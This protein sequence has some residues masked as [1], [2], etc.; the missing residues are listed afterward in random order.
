[1]SKQLL[2]AALDNV[3]EMTKVLEQAKDRDAAYPHI[4]RLNIIHAALLEAKKVL[5]DNEIL[6]ARIAASGHIANACPTV[7]TGS[8]AIDASVVRQA[9]GTAQGV[10]ELGNM[11]AKLAEVTVAGCVKN[12]MAEAGKN[13]GFALEVPTFQHVY[14]VHY[15]VGVHDP[16]AGLTDL[17]GLLK[18]FAAELQKLRR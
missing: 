2:E 17:D 13:G 11:I 7:L 4:T 3:A 16:C 5:A 8:H 18:Q 15:R 6:N 10:S 9:A 14:K 12:L 1:M